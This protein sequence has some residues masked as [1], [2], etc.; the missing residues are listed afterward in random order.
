MRTCAGT[1]TCAHT[2]AHAHRACAPRT[3]AHPQA[4]TPPRAPP[5]ARTNV[6][7]PPAFLESNDVYGHFLCVRDLLITLSVS[8]YGRRDRSLTLRPLN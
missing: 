5:R 7:C 2:V 4:H 1:H 3:Y 6:L 8:K